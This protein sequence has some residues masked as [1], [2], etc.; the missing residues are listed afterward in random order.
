MSIIALNNTKPTF[1][2]GG[3]ELQMAP[4]PVNEFFAAIGEFFTTLYLYI[5]YY[6][7]C[8][9]YNADERDTIFGKGNLLV[10]S[11][12]MGKKEDIAI[13][14]RFSSQEFGLEKLEPFGDAGK[15]H[16]ASLH[17]CQRLFGSGENIQT[18]AQEFQGGIPI[19]GVLTQG[20]YSKLF[21]K[22]AEK[23]IV[24][25]FDV[26][27][28]IRPHLLNIAQLDCEAIVEDLSTDALL[29]KSA[30]LQEGTY[31]ITVPTYVEE[32]MGSHTIVLIKQGKD[33]Y[34]YDPN[35]GVGKSPEDN[36]RGI[37]QRVLDVYMEKTKKDW[38]CRILKMTP[39]MP[40]K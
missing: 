14:A 9:S 25:G 34:L 36:G 13:Y 30:D 24:T 33:S 16:G 38:G 29:K 19:V 8:L 26:T 31:M 28:Y 20:F 3:K 39:K 22:V 2:N 5:Q 7:A 15:C 27:Q 6:L 4:S 23:K 40:P 35:F 21:K 12:N 11:R 17:F 32:R 37:L 18:T 1:P 10:S